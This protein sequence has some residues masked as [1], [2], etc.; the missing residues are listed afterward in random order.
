MNI[1]SSF[2]GR[3]ISVAVLLL[4]AS[5]AISTFLSYRQLSASILGNID[6]YSMLKIDSSS[7]RITDWFQT[8]KEGVIATAP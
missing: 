6:E 3:I 7:D 1:L 5:L 8:I 4:I 2:K